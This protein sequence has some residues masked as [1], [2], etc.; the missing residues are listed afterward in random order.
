MSA[1]F[2]DLSLADLDRSAG[3][4]LAGEMIANLARLGVRVPNGFAT[5][6]GAYRRFIGDTGL[7]DLISAELTGLDTD[8]V[9][10]LSLAPGRGSARPWWHS[11]GP[12]ATAPV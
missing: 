1:G 7:A 11:H 3:K 6:A 5:T 2:A 8:D 4:L 9:Q 10:K 12:P